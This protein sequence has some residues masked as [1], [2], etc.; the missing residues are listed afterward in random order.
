MDFAAAA[1]VATIRLDRPV[2]AAARTR[3][4]DRLDLGRV[5]AIGS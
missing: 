4:A 2:I 5:E 3:V 1:V